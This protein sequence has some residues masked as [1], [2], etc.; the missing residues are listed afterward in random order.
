MSFI[1]VYCIYTYL[2]VPSKGPFILLLQVTTS[3]MRLRGL[4]PRRRQEVGLFTKSDGGYNAM[5]ESW[6]KEEGLANAASLSS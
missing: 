5:K 4:C 1:L 6:L 3:S 2:V